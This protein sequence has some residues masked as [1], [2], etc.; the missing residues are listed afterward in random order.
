ME[1]DRMFYS[2]LSSECEVDRGE[3]VRAVGWLGK[4]HPFPTGSVPPEFLAVL[5]TH[6]RAAWQPVRL[7]GP[8]FCEFCPKPLTG[9]AT[10]GARGMY[11]SRRRRWCTWRRN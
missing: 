2:D 1:A 3:H 5:R 8:H 4:D 6:V 7:M 10:S 9:G 11:G